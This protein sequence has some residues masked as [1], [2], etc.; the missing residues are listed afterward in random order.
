MPPGRTG[1]VRLALD[2]GDRFPTQECA[3]DPKYLGRQGCHGAAA[4]RAGA[5][6]G[7]P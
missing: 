1:D 3:L 4:G 5:L 2:T 6:A 7:E